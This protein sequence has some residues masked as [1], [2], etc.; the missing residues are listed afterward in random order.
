MNVSKY[1]TLFIGVIIF[2]ALVSATA[3]TVLTNVSA[4]NTTF[5]ATGLGSLFATSIFGIL[6][7]ASIFYALYTVVWKKKHG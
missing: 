5:S 6:L 1:I 4:L 7:A 2:S 3:G